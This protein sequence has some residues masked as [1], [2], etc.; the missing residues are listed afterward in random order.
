MGGEFAAGYLKH[1]WACRESLPGPH[2]T[3]L[4]LSNV[5]KHTV[6][7]DTPFCPD[8]SPYEVENPHFTG[9]GTEVE[10]GK[11]F[12]QSNPACQRQELDCE[13]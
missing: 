1:L 9:K 12:G 4:P 3:V 2:V 10:M 8:G 5:Y 13:P 6:S 11:Y 7:S